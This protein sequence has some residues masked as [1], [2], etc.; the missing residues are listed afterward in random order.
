MLSALFNE[1]WVP[2]YARTYLDNLGRAYNKSDL[3]RIA[4]GQLEQENNIE[5]KSKNFLFCDTNL[6]VIK[7]WSEHKYGDCD[8]KIMALHDRRVY[9]HYL[10]TD[11]NIPWEEDPQR[12]NPN[13]RHQ[14]QQLYFDLV[15]KSGVPYTTVSGTKEARLQQ[16]QAV[17][18]NL[19][20]VN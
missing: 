15:Q 4:E 14:F 10:L 19:L 3:L 17:I 2:E 11:F 5:R 20:S 6:L 16:A 8:P 13:H 7:I 12:E 18:Q 1:P 9:H